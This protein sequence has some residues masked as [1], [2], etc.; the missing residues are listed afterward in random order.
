VNA[1]CGQDTSVAIAVTHISRYFVNSWRRIYTCGKS[2]FETK[3][4]YLSQ[5]VN[6]NTEHFRVSLWIRFASATKCHL[7]HTSVLWHCGWK[8]QHMCWHGYPSHVY[9]LASTVQPSLGPNLPDHAIVLH[10]P[11]RV[12][13]VSIMI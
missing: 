13:L 4:N 8:L 12:W 10:T 6:H 7:P 5:S 11:S 3:V 9:R 2:S 1:A